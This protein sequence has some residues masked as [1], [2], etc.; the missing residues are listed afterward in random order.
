MSGADQL[1][2]TLREKR[3]RVVETFGALIDAE[4]S[5]EALE[6]LEARMAVPW[7]AQAVDECIVALLS[8]AQRAYGSM[9]V[10]VDVLALVSDEPG[11]GWRLLQLRM[12]D[13]WHWVQRAS[14]PALRDHRQAAF[15][16]LK[17]RG[18]R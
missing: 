13:S 6:A 4:E 18:L 14:D 3:D 5:P 15:A 12:E 7:A 1:M 10:F 8:L 17:K 2:A 9:R 11:V 16:V